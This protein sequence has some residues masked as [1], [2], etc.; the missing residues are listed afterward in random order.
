[1]FRWVDESRLKLPTLGLDFL[2]ALAFHPAWEADPWLAEHPPTVTWAP[3]VP[4][5]EVST[6]EPVVATLLAASADVGT[7][8]RI[9][10]LDNWHDGAT[11]TRCG[12]TPSVCFGPGDIAL[13]HTVDEH[14]A[15]G[16]LVRCAQALAVSAIRFCGEA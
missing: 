14:V 3:E 10:G 2:K 12:G 7:P 13:A 15:V 9:G 4:S 1:M 6:D 16:D 11:F 8:G 5:S